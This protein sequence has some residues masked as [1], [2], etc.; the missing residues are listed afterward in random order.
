MSV[1]YLLGSEWVWTPVSSWRAWAW[2]PQVRSAPGEEKGRHIFAFGRLVELG[3]GE[4]HGSMF[5]GLSVLEFSWVA[6]P[7][8]M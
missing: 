6:T 1:H 7:A 5:E 4:G 8:G 3:A 2:G